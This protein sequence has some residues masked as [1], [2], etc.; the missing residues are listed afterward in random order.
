[1]QYEFFSITNQ[2]ECFESVQNIRDGLPNQPESARMSY[3]R[4][5]CTSNA[6]RISPNALRITI[7][8]TFG[9]IW[10]QC[11]WGIIII[12]SFVSYATAI[13]SEKSMRKGFT[14]VVLKRNTGEKL[15]I[16][17]KS[18]AAVKSLGI[19]QFGQ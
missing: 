8:T 16:F 17:C 11:D 13:T 6:L 12:I 5:K 3:E 4:Y 2:P 10:A 9:L 18:S 15:N 14:F 19:S 1:M 7:C